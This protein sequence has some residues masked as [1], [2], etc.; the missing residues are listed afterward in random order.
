MAGMAHV[1]KLMAGG[2][3]GDFQESRRKQRVIG[4]I[5]AYF[6]RKGEVSSP[7]RSIVSKCVKY[8]T[9]PPAITDVI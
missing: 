8:G 7:V 1:L 5:L 6:L 4:H 2:L 3:Y 9:W